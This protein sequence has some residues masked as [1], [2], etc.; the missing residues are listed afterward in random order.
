MFRECYA[1]E[2]IHGTSAHV[3]WDGKDV[4]F[5]AGG[6]SYQKFVALFDQDLLR[7]KLTEKVGTDP[8]VIYGEAYGGS[9]QKMS[10]TYGKELKFIVFDIMIGESWLNVP[11]AEDVAQ[12]LA[13]K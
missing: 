4:K 10:H 9:Q 8:C 2:K 13:I 5:F 3:T 1:M 12:A 11:N 6:E 7:Q